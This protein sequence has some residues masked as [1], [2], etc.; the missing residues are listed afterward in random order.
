MLDELKLKFTNQIFQMFFEYIL[1]CS[2]FLRNINFYKN[3]KVLWLASRPQWT[4]LTKLADIK[5]YVK[6]PFE[7]HVFQK[8]KEK[9]PH[10]LWHY[11]HPQIIFWNEVL[12]IFANAWLIG[13]FKMTKRPSWVALTSYQTF[14]TLVIIYQ[15]P[16]V[17]HIPKWYESKGKMRKKK[18]KK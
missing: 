10:N 2:D 4:K 9:L 14:F 11:W 7:H 5:N 1:V 12:A 13:L 16:K 17:P 3:F 6:Y 18:K 15:N 8:R